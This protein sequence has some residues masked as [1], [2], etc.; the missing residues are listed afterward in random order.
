MGRW[1]L[2]QSPVGVTLQSDCIKAPHHHAVI[3]PVVS[4]TG[5]EAKMSLNSIDK[6]RIRILWSKISKDSDAIGAEALG[7]CVYIY[8]LH[9][10]IGLVSRVFIVL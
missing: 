9:T 2:A 5:T 10:T 6:E 1:A 7:R 8:L 3:I 4:S